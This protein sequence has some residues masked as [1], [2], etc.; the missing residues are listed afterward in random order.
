M[1]ILWPE[2]EDRQSSRPLQMAAERPGS[3]PPARSTW[4]YPLWRLAVLLQGIGITSANKEKAIRQPL[5]EDGMG[6][7]AL[8]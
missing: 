6:G 3:Y 1:H 2:E 4:T 5:V 7:G 8:D